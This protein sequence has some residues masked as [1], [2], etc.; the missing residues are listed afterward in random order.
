MKKQGILKL[1]RKN[2]YIVILRP[3]KGDGKVIMGRD[4]Y[5]RKICEVIK[6]RTKFNK[7]SID[8]TFIREDQPQRF[9]RSMEDKK[10]F[11]KE[12]YEKIYASCSNMAFIY[13]MGHLNFTN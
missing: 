5:I 10:I 1:L 8:P 2:N 13:G 6:H 3:D 9:L 11:N 4:V 12:T 7:S